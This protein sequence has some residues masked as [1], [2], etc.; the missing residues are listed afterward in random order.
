MRFHGRERCDGFR[1]N[2]GMYRIVSPGEM[3]RPCSG[4]GRVTVLAKVGGMH[5]HAPSGPLCAEMSL[6]ARLSLRYASVVSPPSYGDVRRLETGAGR[7]RD[8]I[9]LRSCTTWPHLWKESVA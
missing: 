8:Q 6:V 1:R 3:T 9:R 5:F 4:L 7:I 2:N